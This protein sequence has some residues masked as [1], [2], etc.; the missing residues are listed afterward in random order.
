MTFISG[1]D[2]PVELNQSNFLEKMQMMLLFW[3]SS[4]PIII[5]W[6][7]PLNV[8]KHLVLTQFSQIYFSSSSTSVLV[9]PKIYW[10]ILSITCGFLVE[11]VLVIDFTISKSFYWFQFKCLLS[12]RL[13]PLISLSWVMSAAGFKGSVDLSSMSIVTLPPRVISC[14]KLTKPRDCCVAARD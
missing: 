5:S 1:L 11:Y 8:Y 9:Q 12:K 6:M 2:C 3:M 10:R 7:T 14:A 4:Q 13:G